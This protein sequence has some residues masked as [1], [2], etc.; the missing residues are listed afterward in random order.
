M[1]NIYDNKEII[2]DIIIDPLT[3]LPACSPQ[4]AK[5]VFA[6]K[7]TSANLKLR[8][9]TLQRP[10]VSHEQRDYRTPQSRNT[11]LP[12]KGW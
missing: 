12:Q 10:Q 6:C 2:T 7:Q 4:A 5:C 9:E 3:C 8:V 11:P 1:S